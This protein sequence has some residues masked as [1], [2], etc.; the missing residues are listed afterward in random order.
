MISLKS[1]LHIVQGGVDNGDKAWLERAVTRPK[2]GGRWVVPKS[3]FV[4][5][6]VVIYIAGHGLFATAKIAG[7]SSPRK[8]RPYRYG[9]A[10]NCLRL[11]GPPI[12]LGVL[13]QEIPELAWTKYP[14][15]ITTP[16]PIVAAKL[17]ALIRDRRKYR[18][19]AR[20][21]NIF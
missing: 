3:V 4:G 5:D 17:R 12:S 21:G 2:A 7:A 13:Q 16:T 10:I 20:P 8:D 18:G 9:A 15:S 11:I 6:E 14:R 19:A 1:T